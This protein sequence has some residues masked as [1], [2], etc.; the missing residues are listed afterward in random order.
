MWA[1]LGEQ[2]SPRGSVSLVRWEEKRKQRRQRQKRYSSLAT[3]MKFKDFVF[4]WILQILPQ[5]LELS[6]MPLFFCP[7]PGITNSFL[8]SIP[9]T[10]RIRP[11]VTTSGAVTLVRAAA[12]FHRDWCQGLH[13]DLS[14]PA[15][16]VNGLLSHSGFSQTLS[17]LYSK[18]CRGR[19]SQRSPITA[20]ISFPTIFYTLS[21]KLTSLSAVSQACQA[22]S[23]LWAF[24]LALS[25]IS[26]PLTT[27][28]KPG[29]LLPWFPLAYFSFFREFVTF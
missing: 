5:N 2:L 10:F 16:P 15:L 20:L 14:V 12:I 8:S 18:P 4:S 11:P 6:L 24:A 28:L 13:A 22:C 27:L 25:S 23:C 9:N 7:T 26:A 17:I 29:T 21:Y 1:G 19:S 3:G